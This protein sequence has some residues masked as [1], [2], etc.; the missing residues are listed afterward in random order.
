MAEWLR[1]QVANLY[2]AKAMRWFDSNTYR[3][4]IRRNNDYTPTSEAIATNQERLDIRSAE[5][6]LKRKKKREL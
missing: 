4:L 1:Q 3:Q 6:F 5:I 2:I